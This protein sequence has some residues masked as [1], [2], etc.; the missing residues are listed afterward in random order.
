MTR[1][2][3]PVGRG[4]PNSSLALF[5]RGSPDPAL[6]QTEGLLIPLGASL[7]TPPFDRAKV[8]R[9]LGSYPP[10]HGRPG[11]LSTPSDTRVPASL[12]SGRFG[13]VVKSRFSFCSRA[14]RTKAQ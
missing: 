5:G 10:N 8:S 6:R 12:A 13:G 9:R 1:Y 11:P 4:S 7:P 2:L 3:K 14:N